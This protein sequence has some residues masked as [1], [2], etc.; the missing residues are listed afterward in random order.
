[1]TRNIAVT[2]LIAVAAVLA[3]CVIVVPTW[4]SDDNSFVKEYSQHDMLP[5]L[6]VILAIT[7]ASAAQLHLEF[8]KIEERAGRQVLTR[9]R[10]AVRGAAYGLIGLFLAAAALAILKPIFPQTDRSQAS[11]NSL[12]VFILFWN[13]IILIEIVQA[14]FSIPA[15]L[16]D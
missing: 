1:M 13:I 6:G 2:S 11:F 5:I 10:A 12:S 15:K 14:A 8:N 3:V 9:S 4:L 7:L 16:D